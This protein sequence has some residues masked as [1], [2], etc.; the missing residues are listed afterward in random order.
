[1]RIRDLWHKSVDTIRYSGIRVFV[2]KTI[3][4]IKKTLKK[5]DHA[6]HPERIFADV[7]FINGCYLPHPSRYRVAHKREQLFGS[8]VISNEVFFE[9]LTTE[10]VKHYRLFIFFRCP[11][12]E[13]V[14]EVIALA[15][16][17]NKAV[18]FDIDDL[19]I[20]RKYTDLIPYVHSMPADEKRGYD[21]GVERMRRTMLL[22]GAVITTTPALAE[23]LGKYVPEVFLN[24]NVASD[25]MLRLSEEAVYFRDVL[26]ELSDASGA[27]EKKKLK[28]A[29]ERRRKR[30]QSGRITIG[31]FSGSITHND[32]IAMILP[33][34]ARVL[35]KYPQ[36]ELC[37]AGELDI[38][39]ELEAFR[40]RIRTFPFS[41]WREL[42]DRIASVDINIAPLAD[43]IFNRAKSENKWTEASLVKVPTVASRVGAFAEM[44]ADRK[45]GILCSDAE[46]WT[47][48]LSE[49][50]ENPELRRRI[51]ENAYR[52]VREHGCTIST[53]KPL[54]DYLRKKMKPNVA[55]VLPSLQISGGV[56]VAL[57][58]CLMLQEAGYDVTLLN[59][60]VEQEDVLCEGRKIFAV[61]LRET[62]LHGRIDKAVATLWSTLGFVQAYPNIAERYYLVQNYETEFYQPGN[63]FR[64]SAN[65]TY[66]AVVPLRYITISRWCQEWLGSRFGKSCA[67]A[68]NGI[69]R[70]RF[71]AHKRTMR[72]EKVRI[73]VEG[74]SDDYYKNVDES[75]RIVNLLDLE[76]Y[77]IWFMSYQGRPKDWYHVDRFFHRV[78]NEKVGEIYA[79]CD[80]LIKSSIL[81]SF[82]YPPLEMMATGGCCLVAPN[83]GNAEYLRDGEN[84][85]LYEPGNCED[86]VRKLERLVR[87]QALRDKLYENGLA[88]AESRDWK[89]LRDD[90]IALYE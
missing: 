23:E 8:N 27:K 52:E 42:P 10:L 6:D 29:K 80:I 19:V 53:G 68:P 4:Y 74:N 30:E 13:T 77:E 81:E 22:C 85:L 32:D 67:Y 60:G 55:M 88:T 54:A 26:P 78:P 17:H 56:L 24:R 66:S 76:K 47:A 2:K 39:P 25:E 38:P 64:F 75:F 18:L 12:T 71:P 1:M 82:S 90:V 36:A 51:G 40:G 72:E 20:D 37:F 65:Q 83:G 7:L 34:L 33:A 31:Y 15:K 58:H 59:E 57:K 9:D 41:D 43:T 11:Y 3:L 87:D 69:E 50:I 45:T 84:C 62:G 86:A 14:G 48:A 5:E 63:I 44:I 21:E 73:L 70:S 35:K 28:A 16:A 79:Q 46:E 49:L 61:S 89:Y